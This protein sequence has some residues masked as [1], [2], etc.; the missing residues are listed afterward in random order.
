MKQSERSR[1]T[2]NL[3]VFKADTLSYASSK[4]RNPCSGDATFYE[5][6]TDVVE[7]DEQRLATLVGSLQ[8]SERY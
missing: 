4:D 5:M 7:A 3:G 8:S 1:S 2:Q 6:L